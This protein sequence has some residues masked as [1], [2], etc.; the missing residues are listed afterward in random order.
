M[1]NV[2][3]KKYSFIHERN[4][5][6]VHMYVAFFFPLNAFPVRCRQIKLQAQKHLI[7]LYFKERGLF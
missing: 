4:E 7:Y 6:C 3:E 5:K 2:Y 1:K